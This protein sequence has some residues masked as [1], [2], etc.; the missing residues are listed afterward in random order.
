LKT[1]E[2]QSAILKAAGRI[3]ALKSELERLKSGLETVPLWTPAAGLEKQC[4]Q[5][6]QLIDGIAGRLERSLVITLIGPSG[7]GKSTL[8]NA[9]G[10][11]AEISR[12]G[13]ERPTTGSLIVFGTGGDDGAALARDLDGEFAAIPPAGAR[14]PERLCLVD[15]PDTDS[16]ARQRHLPALERAVAHSDILICVFDAENPKR[17]DHADFL[18]PIVRRFEGQSLVAV[19]NKCDRLDEA[20][21]RDAILPDFL[22]YIQAAWQGAVD[23]ALCISARSHIAEPQWDAAAGPRHA[24]DQF[25]ELTRIIRGAAGGA[26]V[27]RRVENA[28]QIRKWVLA[29]AERELRQDHETLAAAARRIAEIDREALAAAAGAFQGGELRW[30]GGTGAVVYQKIAQ[31]WIGPVGWLIA[32][33]ARLLALGSGIAAF[34]RPGRSW[35]GS[36]ALR[37][38]PPQG[39]EDAGGGANPEIPDGLLQRYRLALMRQWPS[40]AEILVSGRFDPV[41]RRFDDAGASADRF[42]SEIASLWARAV[43][44]EANRLVRG[45]SGLALQALVNAPVV[46]VLGH[47]GWITVTRYFNERYLP[48]DFFVHALWVIL[49]VLLLSFIGVQIVIRLAASP[50]RLAARAFERLRPRLSA[51]D[52]LAENPVRRQLEVVLG[53]APVPPPGA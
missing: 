16:T 37:R 35:L 21:L 36:T 28:S 48:G 38:P 20:E 25:D 2:R 9:L 51:M 11:G 31:K 27:D 19:L 40:A 52:G 7:S 8:V 47:V 46:G 18:A 34:L 30:A 33:W 23:R 15:T 17:R 13:R 22:E 26:V 29:E 6:L 53:L 14:L 42:A 32:L 10:G 4:G 50:E 1:L 45:L 41:V 49:I 3:A 5:A 44:A 39:A 43:E 24:F 12:A